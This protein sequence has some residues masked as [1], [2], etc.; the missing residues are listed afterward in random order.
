[1]LENQ[2]CPH[3]QFEAQDPRV[4]SRPLLGRPRAGLR[5][6][7]QPSDRMRSLHE[8]PSGMFGLLMLRIISVSEGLEAVNLHLEGFRL[9]GLCG[10]C[11]AYF[12]YTWTPKVWPNASTKSPKGY[13]CNYVL[14]GPI[15]VYYILYTMYSIP[16]TKWPHDP[17]IYVVFWASTPARRAPGAAQQGLGAANGSPGRGATWRVP[18][19][20]II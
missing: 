17:Y 15:Y 18:G 5:G 10:D 13:Y 14:A 16:Y 4:D 1:M 7:Y 12:G 20:Q 11:R 2:S 6:S 8:W 9:I 19:M 3:P